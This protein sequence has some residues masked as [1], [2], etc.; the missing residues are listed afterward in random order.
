[1]RVSRSTRCQSHRTS[2]VTLLRSDTG[3]AC[4]PAT[5]PTGPRWRPGTRTRP[6]STCES[7]GARA[8][9]AIERVA[10]HF[11]DRILDALAARRPAQRDPAGDR[12]LELGRP[13]HASQPEHALPE[14]SNESRHTSPIGYWTRLPPGDLPNGTPLATG[15]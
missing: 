3:R 11:S 1:M 2:R 12:A 9:R 6:A 4:R 15:H 14:P 7:A 13:R 10:S 8:A 5:C